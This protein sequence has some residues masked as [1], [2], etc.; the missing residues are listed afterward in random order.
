MPISEPNSGLYGEEA[1]LY[2]QVVDGELQATDRFLRDLRAVSHNYSFRSYGEGQRS[3][4]ETK[5]LNQPEVIMLTADK[6]YFQPLTEVIR[7][8]QEHFQPEVRIII[9]DLG[10]THRM[11]TL[12]RGKGR[13]LHGLGHSRLTTACFF[14]VID[15]CRRSCELRLFDKD[16]EYSK[17]S[18]HVL[19]LNTYSFKP[20]IIQV[21]S[22]LLGQFVGQF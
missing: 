5:G 2:L 4:V 18:P 12:V 3:R 21:G 1:R 6:K 9:F 19:N 15:M 13:L 16:G 17:Y 11:R 20:L 10:L 22:F 7:N 8:I 14:K